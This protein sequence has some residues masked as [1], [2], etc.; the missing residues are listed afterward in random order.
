MSEGRV[1]RTGV[2]FV[3]KGVTIIEL[4]SAK[5]RLKNAT[6]GIGPNFQGDCSKESKKKMVCVK[7][8]LEH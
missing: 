5:A 3:G 2:I 4:S 8:M 7:A 6:T 1:C